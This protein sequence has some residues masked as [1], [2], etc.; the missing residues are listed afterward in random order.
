MAQ[1]K[2]SDLTKA[3][4]I[5]KGDVLALEQTDGTKQALFEI[6]IHAPAKGATIKNHIFLFK[7]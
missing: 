2:F 7:Y 1:K 4:Q 3:A 5:N 6:S